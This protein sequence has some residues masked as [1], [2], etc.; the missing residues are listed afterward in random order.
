MKNIKDM[1]TEDIVKKLKEE[2]EKVRAFGFS[3][4]GTR[5]KNVKEGRDAKK[6]IAQLLTELKAR[7]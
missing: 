1:T 4:G 7:A 5:V 6:L 2:Q 3:I